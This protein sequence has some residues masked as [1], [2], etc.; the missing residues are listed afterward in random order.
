MKGIGMEDGLIDVVMEF[1]N[2]IR[3]GY[4]SQVITTIES[5]SGRLVEQHTWNIIRFEEIEIKRSH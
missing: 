4:A 3:A 2:I 1:Y 5:A